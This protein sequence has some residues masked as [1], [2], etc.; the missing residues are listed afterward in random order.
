MSNLIGEFFDTP[1]DRVGNLIHEGEVRPPKNCHAVCQPAG[2]ATVT[3]MLAQ[4]CCSDAQDCRFMSAPKMLSHFP[5]RL[6]LHMYT[7]QY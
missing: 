4:L 6:H 2:E 1:D 5:L 7:N 3:V